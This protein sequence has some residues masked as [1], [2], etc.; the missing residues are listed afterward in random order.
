MNAK[1]REDVEAVK[2]GTKRRTLMNE[3]HFN[4]KKRNSSSRGFKDPYVALLTTVRQLRA[5]K[6]YQ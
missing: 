2:C 5:M 1:V 4:E 6:K 3:I